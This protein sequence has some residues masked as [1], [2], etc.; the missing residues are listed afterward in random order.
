MKIL[1][2]PLIAL[3]IVG[4]GQQQKQQDTTA[5]ETEVLSVDTH[6]ADA[7]DTNAQEE[8]VLVGEKQRN[9]LLAAPYRGWFTSTYDRYELK[10]EVVAQLKPLV[11]DIDF[12]VF[13]GTWC[14]GSREEVPAFFRLLDEL[15]VEEDQIRLIATTREKTT[16]EQLE[17]TFDVTIVPTMI[18]FKDGKELNRI[19]EYPISSLEEDMLK[20]LSGEDY[21]HAY[22]W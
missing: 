13:M 5:L 22:D 9:D 19:V 21:T 6:D 8:E 15:E 12:V 10:Q 14:E 1:L 17:Q 4:C 16:P 3:F 11:S 7:H 18:F 2:L 20:I